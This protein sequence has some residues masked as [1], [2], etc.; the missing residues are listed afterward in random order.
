MNPSAGNE[1][2]WVTTALATNL[3]IRAAAAQLQSAER[4]LRARRSGHLPTIDATVSTSHFVD[5]RLI[6]PRQQNRSGHLR[7]VDH[8]ADLPGRLD[9]GTSAKHARCLSKPASS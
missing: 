1:E 9:L 5:R 4:T 3:T 8:A 2:E 6:V 7:A